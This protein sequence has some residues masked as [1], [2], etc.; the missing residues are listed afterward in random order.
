MTSIQSSLYTIIDKVVDRRGAKENLPLTLEEQELVKEGFLFNPLPEPI[1]IGPQLVKNIRL[2][3]KSNGVD[4]YL[5]EAVK[6][7]NHYYQ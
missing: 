1:P 2:Y 4:L 3:F 6:L 5:P 7:Y